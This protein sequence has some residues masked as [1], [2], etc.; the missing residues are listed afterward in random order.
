LHLDNFSSQDPVVIFHYIANNVVTYNYKTK[1]MANKRYDQF[2][3]GSYDTSKIFLQADA[4]TGAL[5]KINLPTI[6]TAKVIHRA[7]VATAN[8]SGSNPQT[9]ATITIPANELAANG[10]SI[11]IFMH[12]EYLTA[13][14]TK[15]MVV[16]FAAQNLSQRSVAGAGVQQWWLRLIRIDATHLRCIAYIQTG[17]TLSVLSGPLLFVFNP[18]I[19]NNITVRITAGAANDIAYYFATVD[20]YLT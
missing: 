11:Q 6:P 1:T 13:S 5:E 9:M 15:T 7:D 14:G 10:D 8:N 12:S 19:S 18:A 2:S 3:A 4:T 17:L 20:T 16:D